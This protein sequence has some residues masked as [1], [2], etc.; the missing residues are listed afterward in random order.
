MF[1]T[2]WKLIII[3]LSI[4]LLFVYYF[5]KP[6]L[7][8][9]S[10][11]TWP[12][13]VVC[14]LIDFSAAL[15]FLFHIT[16]P[17][18]LSLCLFPLSLCRIRRDSTKDLFTQNLP[19][20]SGTAPASQHCR[21]FIYSFLVS[22]IIIRLMVKYSYLKECPQRQDNANTYQQNRNQKLPALAAFS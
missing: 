8:H 15:F 1:F 18:P 17:C 3:K 16:D 20:Q 9:Y 14:C 2:Q 10:G 12:V 22:C 7:S 21:Y 11:Q 13:F 4:I 19:P 5:L 6:Y